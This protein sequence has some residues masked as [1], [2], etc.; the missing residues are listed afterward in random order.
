MK[1]NIVFI[2]IS[3]LL[4]AATMAQQKRL[5]VQLTESMMS[6][7]S[8]DT[9][10]LK[11]NRPAEWTYEQGIVLKAMEKVWKR[12]GRGDIYHYIKRSMDF[13]IR[14]D[15]TIRTYKME[16]F[17]SDNIAPGRNLLMLNAVDGDKKYY[18]ALRLLRE[19]INYHPRTNSGGFWHKKRYPNQMWLDGL[20]MVEPFW[21]E[22]AQ[23]FNEPESFNDIAKQFIQM[24][25][26]ARDSKTGLLYHGWDESRKEK[27]SDSIT[28]LSQNFWGRA[29]GWYGMALV[30]VLD[31]FPVGHPKRDSLISILRRYSKAVLKVQDA[32]SGVW[33]QVLDKPKEK[34]NYKEASATAMFVYTLAKGVRNGYLDRSILPAINKG[35]AGLQK[36][37]IGKDSLGRTCVNGVCSVAGLGGNPYRD[38]SFEY[39][40]KEPIVTNDVKGVAS[41]ILAANEMEILEDEK[42]GKGKTVAL[43][44]YFNN[45]QKRDERSGLLVGHHYKWE[46]RDNGGFSFLGDIFK[47]YGIKTTAL[48]EKPSPAN[49]KN[50]NI[51]I[52]VDPDFP[53]ENPKPNYIMPDDVTT[54]TNWVKAGGV[55]VMLMNDSNNV[56]FEHSNVLAKKFGIQFNKDSR[57]RVEGHDYEVGAFAAPTLFC[58]QAKKVYIKQISTLK[59]TPPAKSILTDKGDVIMAVAKY[60]KGTVFAVGDPWFYNEYVDGR[61]IPA[62][63]ENFTAAQELVKWL[64]KQVPLKAK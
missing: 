44:Y 45:E 59:V 51:Y 26:H 57:N 10:Q 56:E 6:I 49:L 18:S 25:A 17:N 64:V 3:V 9:M 58:K 28:G 24:E 34:G 20:Y 12:T 22:Y 31:Y 61:K 50:V 52:L 62:E 63:Y 60:G 11:A 7:Y 5:S 39:Y 32:K 41:V 2:L 27:W 48:K 14:P 4:S 42:I 33:Y 35:Y 53:K 21:A 40:I 16:D 1:K 46:E 23:H 55:L 29:M 30:D 19:Q 38:G 8:G 54:I 47:N 36:N 13:F 43:D 37:F 15:G